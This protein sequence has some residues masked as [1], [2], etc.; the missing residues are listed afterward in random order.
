MTL[1]FLDPRTSRCL[2]SLAGLCTLGCGPRDRAVL[3]SGPEAGRVYAIERS[4]RGYECGVCGTAHD[5]RN[6]AQPSTYRR[7]AA[8]AQQRQLRF[9]GA[10]A[11]HDAI[12]VD[13]SYSFIPSC[14]FLHA[15]LRMV[16][17]S[18]LSRAKPIFDVNSRLM[19]AV[20]RMFER[21]CVEHGAHPNPSDALK[22]A[23]QSA[24]FS[25][26]RMLP[27]KCRRVGAATAP[28]EPGHAVPG[29]TASFS[30]PLRV[31]R[32]PSP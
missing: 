10:N 17:L 26:P 8:L 31:R 9:P 30:E 18:A 6:P 16:L 32:V 2:R 29:R 24:A 19:K 28:S 1:T 12:E 13:Q 22:P 3:G 23:W 27:D 25:R 21:C 4:L 15:H 14:G 20:E 7:L 5:V 11:R